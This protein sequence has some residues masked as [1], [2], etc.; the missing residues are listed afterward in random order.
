MEQSVRG[1]QCLVFYPL[2]IDRVAFFE[3]SLYD[4]CMWC[5]WNHGVDGLHEPRLEM[6]FSKIISRS[7]TFV[8][9]V[10]NFIIPSVGLGCPVNRVWT[11]RWH[12]HV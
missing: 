10:L 12:P 4:V 5:K 7:F 2:G 8:S 11:C 6:Y 9:A 3:G 1:T